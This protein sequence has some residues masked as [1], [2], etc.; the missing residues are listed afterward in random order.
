[1][2]T[3]LINTRNDMFFHEFYPYSAV[4]KCGVKQWNEAKVLHPQKC[5]IRMT[6]TPS[7]KSKAVALGVSL[8]IING[9]KS[10]SNPV[11]SAKA[12]I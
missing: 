5:W 1:M 7:F 12:N 8:Q 10:N 2:T 9:S 6:H 4:G 3:S 11:G